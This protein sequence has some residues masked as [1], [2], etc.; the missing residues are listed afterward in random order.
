MAQDFVH[1]REVQST[2]LVHSKLE[3]SDMRRSQSFP[4]M[5]LT[6]KTRSSFTIV[7]PC[8]LLQNKALKSRKGAFG[9]PSK[10]TKHGYLPKRQRPHLTRFF[11]SP[12]RPR[13]GR[14][15]PGRRAARRWR[16]HPPCS[17][18]SQ[19]KQLAG[20]QGG[21]QFDTGGFTRLTHLD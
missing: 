15:A 7:V 10:P 14:P 9:F 2:W 4:Y 17:P 12:D 8:C 1:P 3:V 20:I 21:N 19:G 11:V 5:G 6:R 13:P 16:R 18:Y